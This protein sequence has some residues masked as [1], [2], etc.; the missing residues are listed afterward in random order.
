MRFFPRNMAALLLP[1]LLLLGCGGPGTGEP[2]STATAPARQPQTRQRPG[3]PPEPVED[4]GPVDD[5]AVDQRSRGGKE[6]GKGKGGGT[7]GKG[8]NAFS[9]SVFPPQTPAATQTLLIGSRAPSIEGIEVVSGEGLEDR[10][11]GRLRLVHFWAPWNLL[12]RRSV[13]LLSSLQREFPDQV[14]VLHVTADDRKAVEDFLAETSDQPGT[15]M[16]DEVAGVFATDKAR[17]A[18]EAWQ[19]AAGFTELPTVFLADRDGVLQWFGPALSCERPLRA[20]L[21]GTWNSESAAIAAGIQSAL[22][23]EARQNDVPGLRGRSGRLREAIPDDPESAMLLVDL[24][25]AEEEY[26]EL[27]RAAQ[28]ALAACGEDPETLSRLAWLLATAS[29]NPRVPLEIALEAA[30]RAVQL[31]GRRPEMLET[32]ARVHFRRRSVNDAIAIQQEAVAAANV[33]QRPLLE[34]I[35]RHY[36]REGR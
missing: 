36:E 8:M 20:V 18:T 22:M 1:L 4:E 27:P 9:I 15:R 16:R 19:G 7:G 12:S 2:A 28:H 11:E 14:T 25:M 29:D 17:T 13:L 35:L 26:G 34:A 21:S 32:L 31:S 6:R 3:H 24:L 10:W 23:R 30:S 5:A 33:A